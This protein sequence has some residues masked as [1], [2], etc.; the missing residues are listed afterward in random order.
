[1]VAETICCPLSV[2]R[3]NEEIACEVSTCL[4]TDY[5]DTCQPGK[6]CGVGGCYG[7]AAG[8]HQCPRNQGFYHKTCENEKQCHST[9]CV[10]ASVTK[11]DQQT[12][13]RD[14]KKCCTSLGEESV[15]VP[16]KEEEV[17]LFYQGHN[18][19]G[20]IGQ[21]GSTFPSECHILGTIRGKLK[22]KE[23]WSCA[24][25]EAL[26]AENVCCP[27]SVWETF[28]I[29]TAVTEKEAEVGGL[30]SY[31]TLQY[32]SEC[33]ILGTILGRIGSRNMWSCKGGEAL[34]ADHVCC[35]L[36]VWEHFESIALD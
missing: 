1:M 29:S 15:A 7:C 28:E 30:F 13:I 6:I 9:G 8:R 12:Y 2:W 20:Y 5:F 16:K 33:H 18:L 27:L 21:S 34:V 22:W 24:K 14:K 25:G 36:S 19:S 26:V 32:P 23:V 35:P 31:R 17:G 4:E 11:V 10:D 3:I